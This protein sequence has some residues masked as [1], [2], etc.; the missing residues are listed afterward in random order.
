MPLYVIVGNGV[1]SVGAIEGIRAHD[2]RGDILVVSDEDAPTYGRPLISYFLAG[3]IGPERMSLRPEEFYERHGVRMRLD[4][5]AAGLDLKRREV[6]LHTGETISYDKLLLATGGVPFMPPT[7][8]AEGQDVYF[9]TTLAH[10]RALG[11]VA[12]QVKRVVVVGGG[13]IGLKAAEALF[14]RGVEVSIVE[15][16][17]R[18]L[19]AAFDDEAGALVSKRLAQVGIKVFC[20][21]TAKEILRGEN[22]RVREVLLSN[23][24]A[25]PAEAVVFAIGVIPNLELP[26]AAGLRTDRG[27]L[28]DGR[29]QTSDPNVF[30]AG[31]V[32]QAEDLLGGG[33]KV[34]PIWPNAY[35]QGF[36]AGRNMAGADATYA[37]SLAMNAIAFYGLPTTSVGEVNPPDGQGYEVVR[38]LDG[39]TAVY[40]KLVFKE[41]RLKGCVLLGDIDQAGLY[42]GFIRHRLPVDAAT[43]ERLAQGQPSALLWPGEFLDARFSP[44]RLQAVQF[45]A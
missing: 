37:G 13:L 15:L 29:L 11:V 39:E 2:S 21:V 43:R 23:G 27:L 36:C 30:G 45:P 6:S 9:F 8:G 5:R 42:T 18:V 31:D 33:P 28:V 17:P 44:D 10:A 41:G 34:N 40:R 25:L 19:S 35:S 12:E 14:D 16:A 7:P 22:G 38:H 32:A 24:E 4:V 26:R 20:G 1:A 3:K